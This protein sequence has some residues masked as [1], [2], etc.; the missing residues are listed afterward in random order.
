M[1]QFSNNRN[2]YKS[3][4]NYPSF[5]QTQLSNSGGYGGSFYQ[6]NGTSTSIPIN[7]GIVFNRF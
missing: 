3:I 4:Y 7:F 1:P 6:N 2:I 5:G